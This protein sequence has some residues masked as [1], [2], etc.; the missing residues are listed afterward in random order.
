MS[1][2]KRQ[3]QTLDSKQGFIALSLPQFR[4]LKY[5]TMKPKPAAVFVHKRRAF[6]PPDST[7]ETFRDF[8]RRYTGFKRQVEYALRGSRFDGA[9][10]HRL[11]NKAE[12][13]KALQK[14]HRLSKK[15]AVILV[16]TKQTPEAPI[17]MDIIHTMSGIWNQGED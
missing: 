4:A 1:L 3:Q 2:T 10:R 12:S 8:M 16:S 11:M 9:Y 5:S 7:M 6:K 15:R 13:L 14:L 17:I